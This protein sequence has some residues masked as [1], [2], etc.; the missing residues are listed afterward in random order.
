[1]QSRRHFFG[2]GVHAC[3]WGEEGGA[4]LQLLVTKPLLLKNMNRSFP[5]YFGLFEEGICRPSVVLASI[6]ELQHFRV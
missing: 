6:I 2:G 3:V 4:T 5:T 1:M